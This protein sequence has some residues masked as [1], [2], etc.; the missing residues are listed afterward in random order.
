MGPPANPGRFTAKEGAVIEEE[1]Q[2]IEIRRA[3]LTAEE[4]IVA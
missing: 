3:Q 1:L 4:E 2:Q